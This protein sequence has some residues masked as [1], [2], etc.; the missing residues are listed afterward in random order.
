MPTSRKPRRRYVPRPLKIPALIRYSAEEERRLQLEP[1]LALEALRT[2]RAT[3]ADWSTLATRCNWTGELA[4]RHCEDAIDLVESG[5]RALAAIYQR[6]GTAG[7]WGATG[8]E[9]VALGDALLAADELQLQTTRVEQ[10]AA[11]HFV[12]RAQ[13]RPGQV[14]ALMEVA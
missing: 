7:R 11:L 1:H 13:A 2:G 4:R 8:P 5:V 14:G 3:A 12:L 9:L 6:H 10:R